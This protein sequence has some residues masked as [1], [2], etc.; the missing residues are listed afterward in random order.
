ML[1]KIYG[2]SPESAIGRYS[3]AECIGCRKE[4]IEGDPDPKHVSTSYAERNNLNVRMH[5]RRMTR[6]TNALS[7]KVAEPRPRDGAALPLLQLRAYP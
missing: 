2:A 6:L 3:P 4:R 7:K 1:V 5:S